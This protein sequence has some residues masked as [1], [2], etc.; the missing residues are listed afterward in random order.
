MSNSPSPAL[1]ELRKEIRANTHASETTCVNRLL[2]ESSLSE[3]QRAQVV[4]RGR[5]LVQGCRED[6]DKAGTLDVFMQEFSLSSKEGVA[7]MCLAEALLRVPDAETADDLIAEKILSGNWAEHRGESDSLFVNAST[8]GLMLTGRVVKLDTE[9]TESTDGWMK[10]LVNRV[11]EPVVRLAVSQAMKIMGQQYVLGR[12]IDEA[13]RRGR[14]ENTPGTRFS[15]DMLGEGARTM[16]DAQRYFDAYLAAIRTIGQLETADNV[17]DANGISVKFSALHPRYEYLQ[18]ARVMNEML[19]RVRELALEAKKFGLGFTIDAEEADRLDISLD[20]LEALARDPELANWD[21]LGFVLQAYSKRAPF[22]VDWLVAL[23]RSTGRKFM[24]RLVKG[25]YWDTEIKLAQEEG[26]S[27]Y[28]VYTR[29]ANTDLSYQVC[30]SRLLQA[31]DVIFPQFATHNAH[32]AALVLELARGKAFEF[33]RLHGMGDLLHLQLAKGLHDAPVR[34]YAPVGAHED[35]LPYLVRRLL[36]NGANSSFVNRFMDKQ[37]PVAEVIDDIQQE[38]EASDTRRHAAIPLPVDIFRAAGEDRPDTHGLDLANADTLQGLLSA[39]APLKSQTWTTGPIIGGKTNTSEGEQV[40]SP[41]DTNLVLGHCREADEQ[42]VD[43]TLELAGGAQPAWDALGGTA[44]ADILE[45]AADAMEAEMDHLIGLI[46]LEAGRTLHDGVAEVREAVDFLR[47]YALQARKLFGAPQR[48]DSP[49]G[50]VIEHSLQGRGVFVCISPWNFPLAIFIGPVAAAL[51]AGNSVIAKPAEQT[52]LVAAEGIRILHEAGVPAEVLNFLPGRGSVLGPLLTGDTRVNGVA[53]TGSTATAQRIQRS[54]TERRYDSKTAELAPLIAET[55]GQNAMVVDSSCLPEQVVDDAIQSAFLSAGQRCS[56]LRV[57]YLQDDIADSMIEMLIGAMRELTLGYPWHPET[58]VGPVIDERA[59]QE[60]LEH[61]ERMQ[62]SA[63]VHYACDIPPGLESGSF[64]AP[65]LVELQSIAQLPGEVFGPILHIVRFKKSDLDG[66]VDEINSTGFGLTLGVHSRIES[67]ADLIV[68]RTRVG[69]NYINRNMV[70]AVVGVHPFGGQGLSGTGPKAGGPNYLPRFANERITVVKAPLADAPG[71][72]PA[73]TGTDSTA[74][75]I[76]SAHGSQADWD[77]IGGAYRAT[78][79]EK[80]ATLLA[81]R[82]PGLKGAVSTFRYYAA[83]ARE[84]CTQAITLP[85]PTGE[86]NELSLHGRGVILCCPAP[87]STAAEI[88]AQL[89]AAL[90]AGNCAIANPSEADSALTL[91]LVK[92]LREAGVPAMV[93]GFAP[94]EAAAEQA[95]ADHRI[96]A[97]AFNGEVKIAVA[98]QSKLVER[99]GSIAPVINE[100]ACPGYLQRFA[101]EKTV[102]RNIVATGGNALLLNL[103]ENQT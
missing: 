68:S 19:P 64:V 85:G 25:A 10:K 70:G 76:S 4:E 26:Y 44:R 62:H 17:Y 22:V 88:A 69:N 39:V 51:A 2:A 15:F 40:V 54:L 79:L 66:L 99:G 71:D 45:R 41:A 52:P 95:V 60:L 53:F 43:R 98:L 89:A 11:S 48:Q 5:E 73:I 14:K 6:S 75:I 27:D 100:P 83:Q 1:A 50:G 92:V 78:L 31:Q 42:D 87:N 74:D 49:A 80:A 94:G 103:N 67:F 63:T 12:D 101:V 82:H 8:W 58:D 33:Q 97:A 3:A 16:Q 86:V 84:K 23:G 72:H 36:E 65:H 90:A 102:T 29:K 34:V 91:E 21:G 20:L 35:L 57:M 37:L 24:V 46:S 47:Y 81:E 93:L 30:A 28:P 61:I 9:I 96:S 77:R 18:E 32:T 38:V 55:G 56:A 59:R 7:L 13:M